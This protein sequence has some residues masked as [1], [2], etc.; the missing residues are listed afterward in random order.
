LKESL[1]YSSFHSID[2]YLSEVSSDF[3]RKDYGSARASPS[4]SVWS[5]SNSARPRI[6]TVHSLRSMIHYGLYEMGL[7]GPNSE[8][9]KPS[10]RWPPGVG[11]PRV[12]HGPV[13]KD[14][15]LFF[16]K[17]RKSQKI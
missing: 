12:G 3:I 8:K 6:G 14:Q 7:D 11:P 15:V 5:G 10:L 17:F 2:V 4:R 13:Q 9:F 1:Y 16:Y